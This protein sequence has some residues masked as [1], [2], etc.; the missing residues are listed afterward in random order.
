MA[1]KLLYEKHKDVIPEKLQEILGEMLNE[2]S[3]YER[4]KLKSKS[5]KDMLR[6]CAYITSNESYVNVNE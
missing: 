1:F 6:S 3:E 5:L 4:V 2:L